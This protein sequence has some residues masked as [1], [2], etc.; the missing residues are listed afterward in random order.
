[1]LL[2]EEEYKKYES[3]LKEF[4]QN[5]CIEYGKFPG[6]KEGTTYR[7]MFYLRRAMF[8]PDML[9]CI[10]EMMLYR[11]HQEL[12]T[13]NFQVCGAE[14]AGTPLAAS[15]PLMSKFYGNPVTGFVVRKEQKKYGLRNWHEGIAYTEPPYVLVDDLCNSSE[16]LNRADI[17]CKEMGLTSTNLAIVIVNKVNKEIHSEERFRTDMYLPKETK[18][19]SLFDLNTFNLT[20]PSH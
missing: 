20:G 11:I 13:W 9:Y 16:S 5:N 7:W 4:I 18:V 8:D 10:S 12:N 3:V 14:T 17:I 6:K 2:S 15:L 1:M 19:I